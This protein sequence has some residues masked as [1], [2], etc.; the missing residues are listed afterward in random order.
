MLK[1]TRLDLNCSQVY[2][3]YKTRQEIEQSCKVY[4]NTLDNSASYM[5]DHYSFEAWLFI[6]HFALQLLYDSLDVVARRQKA[7][8]YSFNDLMAHLRGVR[9]NKIDNSW[10]LTKITKK[11]IAMCESIGISFPKSVDR[12]P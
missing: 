5:R 4:D 9:I 2:M 7:R 10:M 3:L 11:T 1:T 12:A 6:N 8:M